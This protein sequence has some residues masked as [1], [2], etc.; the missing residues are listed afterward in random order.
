[1]RLT[2]TDKTPT[3]VTLLIA[4]DGDDLTPIKNHVLSHFGKQN[5]EDDEFALQNLMLNFLIEANERRVKNKK[6]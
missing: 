3:Q 1:M 5:S 6:K 2:R 4:A